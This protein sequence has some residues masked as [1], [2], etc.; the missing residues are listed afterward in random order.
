MPLPVAAGA[1]RAAAAA[2]GAGGGYRNGHRATRFIPGTRTQR[3]GA[4]RAMDIGL[5]VV[6]GRRGLDRPGSLGYRSR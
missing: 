3:A 6:V 5:A 4:A 2:P 1:G